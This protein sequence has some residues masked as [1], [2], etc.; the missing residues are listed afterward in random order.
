VTGV[1]FISQY[2]RPPR[3]PAL[4]IR[5]AEADDR[6]AVRAFLG[7][8]SPRTVQSRYLQRSLNLAGPSGDRELNR[9][10]GQRQAGHVVVLA[11]DGP[12]V[13]GI[14]EFFQAHVGRADVGV[15]VEDAFQGRGI[16]RSL[17]RTLERAARNRGIRAFTGDMAY[18]NARAI[19]L[20]Q[21][22][23]RHLTTRVGGGGVS[24]T[25]VLQA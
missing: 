23:G 19:A 2:P 9:L 20:L 15:V 8:L 5:A 13:R 3:R 7:R 18:G 10:L 4:Q 16:G 24:F 11:L 25:L 22:T 17:L 14:G 1:S 12:D 21:A 6:E